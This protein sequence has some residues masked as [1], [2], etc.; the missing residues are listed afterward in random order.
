M[1]LMKFEAQ[2]ILNIFVF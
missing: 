1:R 2:R